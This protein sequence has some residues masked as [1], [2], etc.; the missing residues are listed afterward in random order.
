M[1]GGPVVGNR[2]RHMH[3]MRGWILV[4]RVVGHKQCRV[5]GMHG[6]ILLVE[7]WRHVIASVPELRCWNCIDRTWRH[8]VR[9]LHWL[10]GGPVLHNSC[11]LADLRSMSDWHLVVGGLGLG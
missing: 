1:S 8:I 5:H 6:W 4:H 2:L 3:V 9:C 11:G 10:R 7:R